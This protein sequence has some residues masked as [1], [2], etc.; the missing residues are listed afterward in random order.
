MKLIVA[1]LFALL[2]VA[3]SA[4]DPYD[5]IDWSKVVPVTELP[6]FWDGRDLGPA[7]YPGPQK[8]RGGRIVG[9][10][11]VIP[12]SHPYQAGLLIAF[13][14]GTGLCGGSIIGYRTILTAAHC[15]VGSSNTL[16]ILGAHELTGNEATQHRQTVQSW[17]YRVHGAYNSNNLNNDIS[18]LILPGNAP[19][20]AHIQHAQLAPGNAHDFNGEWATMSGWGGIDGGGTS[21]HL[22]STQNNV[23]SNGACSAVY[24]GTVIFSTICTSTAGGRSTCGGDSG[25][26]LTVVFQGVRTQIGV[27]S[28]VAGA[29]CSAG[30]PAGFARVSS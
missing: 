28:F 18:I 30:F 19:V 15:S 4:Q 10:G 24:G 23:I 29:G 14:G 13:G 20:N 11:I 22:R 3:A 12:H 17:A 2:A 27:T 26:P 8:T 1:A 9:G 16:V 5:D 21:S 7:F 6:G 25:G